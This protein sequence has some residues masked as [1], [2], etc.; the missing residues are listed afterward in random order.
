MKL[1]SVD[2]SF[3]LAKLV[4]FTEIGV[5]NRNHI[6]Y[7]SIEYFFDYMNNIGLWRGKYG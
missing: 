4:D 2:N 7:Q 5:Y 6:Y 1:L 3:Y